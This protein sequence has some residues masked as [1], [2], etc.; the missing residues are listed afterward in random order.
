MLC[1]HLEATTD[2]IIARQLGG[3][4]ASTGGRIF[5]IVLIDPGNELANRQ[6]ITSEAIPIEAIVSDVGVGE[7][8]QWPT[9]QDLHPQH[10]ERIKERAITVGFFE[11]APAIGPSMVRQ[12][13]PYP[14]WI[15]S[16]TAIENK[17]SLDRPGDLEMQLQRDVSLGLVD[18]VILATES[19]VT[20]AHLNRIPDE[21]GVWRIHT[22]GETITREVVR[23]PTP[24]DSADWGIE[25]GDGS[26]TTRHIA[27]V[28][29]SDKE[30]A[31]IQLAERAYGKGWRPSL[32]H[33]SRAATACM[34]GT[35]TLPYCQWKD[36]IIDPVGCTTACPEFDAAPPPPVDLRAEREARTPWIADPPG[37]T[38]KQAGLTADWERT[39]SI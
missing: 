30:Q 36:V 6:A 7:A 19:H 29:P 14:D 25:I 21:V 10:A 2:A 1:A 22:T 38:R 27:T 3:G 5:D 15:G 24:L 39:K 11:S 8:R 20:G 31:R 13:T 17:P 35:K 16:I 12:T 34:D 33:C 32:P 28:M 18:A 23:E 9:N 4:V 26:S 37:V